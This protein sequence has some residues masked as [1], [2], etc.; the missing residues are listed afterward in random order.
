[1][2]VAA[3]DPAQFAFGGWNSIKLMLACFA[4]NG[5]IAAF[6]YLKQHPLPE[7]EDETLP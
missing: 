4:V 6:A 2:A 5:A 7:A 3:M 1:V